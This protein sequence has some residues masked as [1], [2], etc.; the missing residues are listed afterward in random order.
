MFILCFR[1]QQ[2]L[3]LIMAVRYLLLVILKIMTFGKLPMAPPSIIGCREGNI[4]CCLL[5]EMLMM[6]INQKEFLLV[7]IFLSA[8]GTT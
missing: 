5:A 3:F 8:I 6:K 1:K 2:D 7:T 4:I